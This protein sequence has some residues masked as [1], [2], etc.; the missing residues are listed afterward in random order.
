LKKLVYSSLFQ[1]MMMPSDLGDRPQVP[2]GGGQYRGGGRSFNRGA[3]L[4]ASFNRGGGATGSFNRGPVGGNFNRGGPV[5]SQQAANVK[6]YLRNEL[7]HGDPHVVLARLESTR[8]GFQLVERERKLGPGWESMVQAMLLGFLERCNNGREVNELATLMGVDQ[9]NWVCRC[10]NDNYWFRD[11]CNRNNCKAPKP[12]S[13]MPRGM[14]VLPRGMMNVNPPRDARSMFIQ[15]RGRSNLGGRGNLGGRFEDPVMGGGQDWRCPNCGNHNWAIRMVC[16]NKSC[17]MQ[18]PNAR[19]PAGR[20]IWVCPKCSNKNYLHREVCNRDNC[21]EERPQEIK[22]TSNILPNGDWE[23]G[24]CGNVNYSTRTVCNR[25]TCDHPAPTKKDIAMEGPWICPTCLNMNYADRKYCNKQNCARPRPE[26]GGYRPARELPNGDWICPECSN[27]NFSTRVVCNIKSCRTPNPA[28]R[29]PGDWICPECKNVNWGNK[30][31]CNMTNCHAKKPPREVKNGEWECPACGNFN[32]SHREVC[33]IQSCDEKRPEWASEIVNKF[34]QER[35]ANVQKRP[36]SDTGES[37][38][39]TK[40]S[41]LEDETPA[42]SWICPKCS[43]LN[44][45]HRDVC[46]K[47]TCREPRPSLE[48]IEEEEVI[49]GDEQA[50]VNTEEQPMAVDEDNEESA[51]DEGNVESYEDG[52]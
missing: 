20:R 34:L 19:D 37:G 30:T 29:K 33:N 52:Q 32:F 23:C 2:R 46:N 47:R 4:G 5:F 8:A 43:N 42:G 9:S 7:L 18:N 35:D 15:G 10:G 44:F 12:V 26:D 28:K 50:D 48:L 38:E 14:N 16:N 36:R 49:Q 1:T 31:V 25:R 24:K 39:M 40:K 6:S 3:R 21:D 11:V 17:N 13:Y 27:I 51:Y 45:P 22:L 41:K